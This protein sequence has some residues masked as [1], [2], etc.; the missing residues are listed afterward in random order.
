MNGRPQ[1]YLSR[2]IEPQSNDFKP[3]ASAEW[4]EGRQPA[5]DRHSYL[6]STSLSMELSSAPCLSPTNIEELNNGYPPFRKELSTTANTRAPYR[7]DLPGELLST[8]FCRSR[9]L[10]QSGCWTHVTGPDV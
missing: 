3:D 5:E 4:L 2:V 6:W 1:D 10:C 9:R 7:S 8:D